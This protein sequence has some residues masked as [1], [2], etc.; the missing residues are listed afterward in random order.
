MK[1]WIILLVFV[2]LIGWAVSKVI[3]V[4]NTSVQMDESVNASWSQ[5]LNNYQRRSDLI[6][7]LVATVK[8]YAEH[9]SET[10]EAVIAARARATQV[11]VDSDLLNNPSAMQ[12]FNSAQTEL[13]SALA[14]LMAVSERYPDLKANE[15]FLSLQSQLEGTENRIAVAR[16]DFIEAVQSFNVFYRTI[17]NNWILRMFSHLEPKESFMISEEAQQVPVVDFA[18]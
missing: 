6:P 11:T 3:S 9:E 2:V 14:R 16:K 8:G 17:P 15:N 7:N 5:V 4:L 1:K 13:G 10:L 18:K 12:A